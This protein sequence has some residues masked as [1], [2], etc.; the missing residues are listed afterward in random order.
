MKEHDW[1]KGVQWALIRNRKP[2]IIPHI[3]HPL[4]TSNFS[5]MDEGI[6]FD[7]DRETLLEDV[8]DPSIPP[9]FREF[10]YCPRRDSRR[11]A[12]YGEEACLQWD[13]K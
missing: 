3:D 9:A 4:D 7:L 11:Q 10:T 2:P 1:F 12:S 13:P 5:I 6:A 8:G